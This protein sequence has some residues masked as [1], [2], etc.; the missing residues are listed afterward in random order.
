MRDNSNLK[1]KN[2]GFQGYI[3]K[4]MK[5]FFQNHNG[6]LAALA[7]IVIFLLITTNTFSKTANLINVLR[8]VCINGLVAAGLTCVLL[9]GCMDLSVG[10]ICAVAGC[11]VVVA[12]SV[13]GL[14]V[15]MAV[16]LAVFVGASCGL[17]N[18]Y[19]VAKTGLP[20]FVVTIATQQFLRGVALLFTQ[21]KPV[22]SVDERFNVIGNGYIGII[23]IPVYI[24]F[25]L[26][27]AVGV[28]LRQ[29]KMGRHMYT[30]GGNREAAIHSG[31]N[32]PKVVVFA[33]TVCGALCSV[34]GI[35]L[36]AR[37]Y[38]GQPTVGMDYGTDG[39]AA[40]VIGGTAFSGGF[41]TMFGTLLGVLI[42]GVINNGMN[43]L[44]INVYT[45][46]LTKGLIIL[47]AVYWD[48]IKGDVKLVS[49]V[50]GYFDKKRGNEEKA[51]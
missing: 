46:M 40:A 37:M 30:V 2:S 14:P 21:G 5:S 23:P 20:P 44:K 15:W 28:V 24:M 27:F 42:I 17:F 36:A 11:L 45:Q 10:S 35:I 51:V 41:G 47:G 34:A 4:S 26:L 32:Y 31:I 29:T 13:W 22:N 7:V 48:K 3:K 12:N 1:R 6:P 50:A 9:I 38:S 8:Q 39:I 19:V 16:S 49:Q 25:I 18:G 43:L 33:Y